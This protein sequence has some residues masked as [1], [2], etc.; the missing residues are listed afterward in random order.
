MVDGVWLAYEP[1]TKNNYFTIADVYSS[2]AYL[3][4]ES[5]LT[6]LGKYCE[7]TGYKIPASVDGKFPNIAY[8]Y[9]HGER[10][11]FIKFN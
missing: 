8:G 6:K 11:P 2:S 10:A 3:N 9:I 4:G 7:A 1:T 5:E